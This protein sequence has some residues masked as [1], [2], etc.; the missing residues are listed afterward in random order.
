MCKIVL[1]CDGFDSTLESVSAILNISSYEI[2]NFCKSFETVD[3]NILYAEIMKRH[4]K[5]SIKNVDYTNLFHMTRYDVDEIDHFLRYGLLTRD[6]SLNIIWNNL[7]KSVKN[8]Q[9]LD[10][11][12]SIKHKV[13]SDYIN[14]KRINGSITD[15]GP[16]GLL[17]N[18]VDIIKDYHFL[19]V[20]QGPEL[21]EDLINKFEQI[22][23]K[24]MFTSFM[25][26]KKPILIV[27]RL[28]VFFEKYL[29][30]ALW[31][32][33]STINQLEWVSTNNRTIDV[34]KDFNLFVNPDQIIEIRVLNQS[35]QI[36]STIYSRECKV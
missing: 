22:K 3:E 14:L 28:K 29:I 19:N 17:I 30:T 11:F 26:T 25:H 18:D 35:G 15:D 27:F 23:G 33:Y 12:N 8:N 5:T 36:L 24:I 34:L 9:S 1:N 10:E 21:I 31:F 13:M 2:I 16:N 6:N 4:N 20:N 7:Y 32:I